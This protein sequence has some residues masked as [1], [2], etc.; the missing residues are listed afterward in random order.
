MTPF[1]AA[2]L[3][4]VQGLTEFLPVSSS[5]HLV[6][7]ETLLG[8]RTGDITFEVIVHFGTLL[9]VVTALRDRIRDLV[10]GCARRDPAAW[11]TALALCVG[12]VPAGVVGLLFEDAL[13]AAFSDPLAVS[14]CLIVTGL[15]LWST[16]FRRGHRTDVGFL[17]ALCIGAAQAVAVLPGISR[18]GATISA[19]VWRGVDGREAAAFSFLL[20]VPVILGAT[21][22]KVGEMAAHPPAWEALMPLLIGALAAYASGVV[23]IRW[24]LSLL[25]RGRLDRFAYY[26]WTI[27]VL[28][29]I[30]FWK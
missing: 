17:D 8:I 23:A 24:L 5:G 14:G 13:E 15:I 1:Q 30:F 26:C 27:G 21:V 3:G 6:L 7:G 4:L 16:R 10:V 18:S 12:T 19:G 9:A 20:S 11:R 28:G 29:V 25:R 22:L 2:I